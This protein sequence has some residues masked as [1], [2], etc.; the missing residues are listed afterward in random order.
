MGFKLVRGAYM[1]KER[2]RANRKKYICHI[3]KNK[4][5][6]DYDYNKAS[7]YC[8]DNIEDMALCF[9]THNEES[10]ERVVKLMKEKNIPNNDKR[11]Y[12]SQ[13][14]GMSDNI[15]FYLSR[16]KY[17]VAKYVPYGPVKEVLPYLIRRAE[18]NSA[19]TGQ[20]NREIIRIQELI[21]NH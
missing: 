8:I 3:H 14:L 12:F 6:C 20:T 16:F 21:K 17:N 7:K 9:G 5:S 11:I 10:T 4:D 1:E 19:I 13:L 2:I 15:S 18:E